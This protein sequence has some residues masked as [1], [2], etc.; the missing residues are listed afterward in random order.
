M[1]TREGSETTQ[2]MSMREGGESLLSAPM[3]G[4]PDEK[5]VLPPPG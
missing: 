4:G 2:L 1:G 5:A 3:P